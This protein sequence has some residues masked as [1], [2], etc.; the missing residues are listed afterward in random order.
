MVDS[1][2]L[3]Q[4]KFGYM[5][6]AAFQAAQVE[7]KRRAEE[8]LEA[9]PK[10]RQKVRRYKA[11]DFQTPFATAKE[12]EEWFARYPALSKRNFYIVQNHWATRNHYDLRV[13]LDGATTSWAVPATLADPTKQARRQA[14]E[15]NPH[16]INYSLFEGRDPNGPNITG[17]WDIFKSR[18]AERQ[19]EKT[20]SGGIDDAETTDE[21]AT[22]VEADDYQ[23]HLFR[24][25]WHRCVNLETPAVGCWP[26][27]PAPRDDGNRH[28]FVLELN[29]ER[30]QGLR[31]SF[32]HGSDEVKHNVSKY[33]GKLEARRT[34]LLNLH[35][36]SKSLASTENL[37]IPRHRSLLTRRTM[38]EIG[39]DST[40]WYKVRVEADEQETSHEGSGMTGDG[41]QPKRRRQREM[42]TF[43]EVEDDELT[44]AEYRFLAEVEGEDG[45]QDGTRFA[46]HVRNYVRAREGR[47]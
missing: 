5:S 17:V 32:V 25:A 6:P 45:W 44:R 33:T 10:K 16:P 11:K 36:K 22:P 37:D 14:I 24:D 41:T 47:K 27:Q 43:A 38:E 21:D 35:A 42:E 46:G 40:A 13:Q 34:W 20:R 28:G 9:R 8:E 2:V 31:L 3:S 7:A 39:R 15:T 1:R 23:E 26:R 12:V 30:Y 29:G 4:R 18:R 19:D